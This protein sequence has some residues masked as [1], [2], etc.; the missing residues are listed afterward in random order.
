MLCICFMV[1]VLTVLCGIVN[2]LNQEK[3]KNK[4]LPCIT[5]IT[6]ILGIKH[7]AWLTIKSLNNSTVFTWFLILSYHTGMTL[8][9]HLKRNNQ[10]YLKPALVTVS[11]LFIFGLYKTN[12]GI[13]LDREDKS[14]LSQLIA[15]RSTDAGEKCDVTRLNL[16]RS[17]DLR[18]HETTHTFLR[19]DLYR[20]ETYDK[21]RHVLAFLHIQKT[22]GSELASFANRI[23]QNVSA[24]I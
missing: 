12:V 15:K 19:K 2:T 22:G 10:R 17:K 11:I 13:S 20:K 21:N 18:N 9:H 5:S 1:L 4:N 14:E 8:F 24:G 16:K 7:T 6:F 23:T 3:F